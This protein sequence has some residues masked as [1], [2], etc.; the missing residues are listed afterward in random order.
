MSKIYPKITIVTPVKNSQ[1]TIGKAIQSV[2]NQNY[3]NLEYIVL[4]GGST[5]GT[6][7]IIKKYKTHIDYFESKDDGGNVMAYIEGIK[8]ASSDIIG[9]LNADDFYEP[10]ILLKAGAEFY[11]N[12]DLD[13]I[14][15]CCQ[16]INENGEIIEKAKPSDMDLDKNKII[17]VLGINARFFKKELFYKYGFPMS[18]DDNNRAFFS[19]DLEYMIRFLFK[20]V[21]NKNIDY[22]GYNYLSH[23]NS[24][25]FS[26]NHQNQIR[27]CQDKIYIAKKFL[28]STELDIPK[29]WQKAF[30]KW[31]KKYRALIVKI[32]LKEKKTKEALENMAQGIKEVG[33]FKFNFYLVKTLIRKN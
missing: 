27:L 3:P 30:K 1:N 28:N 14:S 12:P 5:D 19:N 10:R 11:T 9:F 7:D 20:G 23:N 25:T 22:I 32:Y 17:K 21:K 13:I 33:F 15:F 2:V 29:I 8:K 16:I 6:L 24:L 31:I 4:D 26:K 18:E